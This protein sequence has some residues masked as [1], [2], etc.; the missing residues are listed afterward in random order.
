MA[1]KNYREIYNTINAVEGFDPAKVV[2]TD[3]EGNL[4]LR[5]KDRLAWFKLKHPNGRVLTNLHSFD[6][7]MAIVKGFVY[8]EDGVL[9]ATGYGTALFSDKD[10][11]GLKPI[12]CAET[13]AI[14]RALSNA[15]F[16]IQF[17]GNAYDIP[18]AHD[19]GFLKPKKVTTQPD[20]SD[21]V[22]DDTSEKEKFE[23]EVAENMKIIS[24]T[25]SK[26]LMLVRGPHAGKRIVEVY[27]DEQNEDK[28]YS[29]RQ[30]AY[31]ESFDD[32]CAADVA[33]C[34]VF[35]EEMLKTQ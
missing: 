16:G 22:E 13:Y 24:P 14:G 8:N 12:E 26:G 15:G 18:D 4:V 34:R 28:L 6:G 9:C 10:A 2:E 32:V 19:S 23:L 7:N 1:K 31:P 17:A 35:Y 30:Y 11:F 29:I 21:V 5:V 33:A 20:I 27:K 3:E 25:M